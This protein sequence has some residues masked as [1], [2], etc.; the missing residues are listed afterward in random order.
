[1][2]FIQLHVPTA[3]GIYNFVKK[4]KVTYLDFYIPIIK[5]L[6]AN[7]KL[8]NPKNLMPRLSGRHFIEFVTSEKSPN[9][10]KRCQV[11]YLH[12]MKKQTSTNVRPGLCVVL[13]FEM[14]HTELNY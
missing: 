6:T 2:H 1:M 8:P 14:Y 13:C 10:T 11:S 3:L 9:P 12:R 7:C 5:E 4:K